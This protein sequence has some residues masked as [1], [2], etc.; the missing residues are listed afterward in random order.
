MK[1]ERLIYTLLLSYMVI[2]C[3]F[4]YTVLSEPRAAE[5]QNCINITLRS[6]TNGNPTCP[7]GTLGDIVRTGH[8]PTN[9]FVNS[10]VCR[11]PP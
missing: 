5:A 3:L 7:G 9:G 6:A 11:T 4:G 10:A 8:T 2:V 1:N